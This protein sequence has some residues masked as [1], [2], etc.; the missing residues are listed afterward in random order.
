MSFKV[1]FLIC[2]AQKGGTTAL[3]DYLRLH[4]RLHIPA[5]KELHFFDNEKI[6]WQ[7]P[8]YWHY[9]RSYRHAE[10][11]QIWGDAT[12]VYMYWKKSAERIWRY[13]PSIRLITIL[14]N[15]ITRAYSHWSMEASR[16]KETLSFD[17]ALKKEEQ[18][19]RSV[20][21]K[22]HRRFS[23]VDRGYYSEQL[24]RLWHFFGREAVLVLRQDDLLKNP[25]LCLSKV[26]QHLGI[27]EM[28]SFS[29]SL[30]RV[31]PS[32]EPMSLWAKAYLTNRYH[33]E[34]TQL[35]MMLGWNCQPWLDES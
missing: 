8:P 14:R 10:L 4:P 18:R 24:R 22:Q 25:C 26:C 30:S 3:A 28:P 16:G 12:P 33:A 1:N 5:R 13:N 2:G 31:G 6:S 20:L 34:I 35:E 29:S 17:E 23:Y 19:C 32:K 15:P 9:H 11:E 21:P 7:N 27:H